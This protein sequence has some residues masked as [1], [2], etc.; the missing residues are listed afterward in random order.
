MRSAKCDNVNTRKALE[1]Q[2]NPMMSGEVAPLFLPHSAVIPRKG[3]GRF[4]RFVLSNFHV[5]IWSSKL[6]KNLKPIV[7]HFFKDCRQPEYVCGQEMCHILADESG[8]NLPSPVNADS[9]FFLKFLSGA[10]CIQCHI[11]SHPLLE[12]HY[13]LM[14]PP[15][16][17]SQT[18]QGATLILPLLCLT[19]AWILFIITCRAS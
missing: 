2:H 4:L 14:T 1:S 19:R 18:L 15:T 16:N 17:A 7:H 12:P 3:L 5:V 10:G 6:L 8:Q 13:L 9:S 11:R